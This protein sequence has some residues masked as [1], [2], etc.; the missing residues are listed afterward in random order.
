MAIK[1]VQIGVEDTELLEVPAGIRFAVT[2]IMICNTS[3]PDPA[4]PDANAASFT[5]HFVKTGDP[6]SDLNTV[7]KSLPLPAG[8]TFTFDTE[9]IIMEQFDKI[10]INGDYPAGGDSSANYLSATTSFLEL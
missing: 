6:I 9:K 4:D 10:V 7:I 3:E 2:V 5:M 1:S 8:E